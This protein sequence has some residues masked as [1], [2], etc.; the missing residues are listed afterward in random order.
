MV[1]HPRQPRI[2][3]AR[4]RGGAARTPGPATAARTGSRRLPTTRSATRRRRPSS[5]ATSGRDA[6]GVPRP[7]RRGARQATPPIVTQ[8]GFGVTRF[9]RTVEHVKH[10]LAVFVDPVDPVKFSRLLLTNLGRDAVTLSVFAY[11]AVVARPA[12]R[13]T[14]AARRHR[15]R[16]GSRRRARAQSVRRSVRRTRRVPR[17]QRDALRRDGRSRRVSSGAIRR[18]RRRKAS[19]IRCCP[20]ASARASIRA[21]P[22]RS[23]SRSSPARRTSLVFVLGQGRD[24][25]HARQLIARH[26]S[27][28]R[29]AERRSTAVTE[30]VGP[31]AWRDPGEDAGRFL[32]PADERLAALSERQQPAVGAH[33]VLSTERRVRLSRSA[34]GRHGA[35]ADAAGSGARAD[36]ARGGPPVR[37]G[38]RST[39]VASGDRARIAQ[40]V[41]GRHAVAALRHGALRAH[42]RRPRRVE[43][44]DPVHRGAAARS[45][46]RRV[47]RPGDAQPHAGDA[48][49]ALRARDPEGLDDRRA[50][51]AAHRQRRLERRHESRRARGPRA[52]APGWAS[53]ST[54]C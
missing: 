8:H 20:I 27:P 34:A 26:A 49:R 33:G 43:R 3:H 21:R 1:E 7:V 13:G 11:A 37:R 14:V 38:R 10:E 25:D 17:R 30:P 36:P 22:C 39:L 18:L 47:L 24:S 12:A 44:Q 6:S 45:R 50:R 53:S 9:T 4:H 54:A 48:L 51:P 31:P 32:R 19:P 52:R 2:R 16:A 5:F 46:R 23:T 35:R 28:T 15:V 29:R 42:D 40:P 41:L